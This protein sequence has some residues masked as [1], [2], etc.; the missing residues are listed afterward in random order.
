MAT[1]AKFNIKKFGCRLLF[2]NITI[3]IT[4][5]LFAK[6]ITSTARYLVVGLVRR[7][8]RVT[9]AHKKNCF[10]DVFRRVWG[11]IKFLTP[12]K[13]MFGMI[14]IANR[15]FALVDSTKERQLF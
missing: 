9:Y 3:A 15:Y 5:G 4:V 11:Q 8:F 6:W 12:L 10:F 1:F 7:Y 14:E 2:Y 13:M